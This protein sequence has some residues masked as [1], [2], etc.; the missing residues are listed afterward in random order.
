MYNIIVLIFAKK[1]L[2]F[3][4][5]KRKETIILRIHC[6]ERIYINKILPIFF[7]ISR[8]L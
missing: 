6:H 7:Q 1:D 5:I 2:L 8:K 4:L 3:I